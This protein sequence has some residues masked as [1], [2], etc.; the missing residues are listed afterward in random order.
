MKATSM[1]FAVVLSL[2]VVTLSVHATVKPIKKLPTSSSELR[3]NKINL[4]QA[5]VAELTNSFTG[6]GKKRAEAIVKYRETQ[7]QF[8]S[9]EDLASV[10]GLGKRFVKKHLTQLQKIF[11]VN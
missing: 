5:D 8:K 11:V 2:F 7:G 10:R 6:I 1:L 9:I 3:Y 4:N